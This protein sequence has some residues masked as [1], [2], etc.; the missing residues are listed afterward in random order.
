MKAHHLKFSQRL[1]AP[2]KEAW[3]FFSSPLNLAKITPV[4][5]AITVTSDLNAT[6]KMYPGMIITYK[7][8]PLMGI[9]LNWITEITQVKK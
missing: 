1:P 4:E 8:S 5:M 7:V 2:L 3:D 6:V 9:K